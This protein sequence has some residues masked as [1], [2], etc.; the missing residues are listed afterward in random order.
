VSL[1]EP[2][3]QL[4]ADGVSNVQIEVLAEGRWS[5]QARIAP[6][7]RGGLTLPDAVR[8]RYEMA[9][10]GPLEHVVLTPA[11]EARS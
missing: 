2:R 8:L 9:G 5:N 6:A 7:E 3:R 11:V 4:L 10:F 1:A